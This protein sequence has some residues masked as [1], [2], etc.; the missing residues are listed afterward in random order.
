[1]KERIIGEI[2]EASYQPEHWHTVLKLLVE[3]THSKS[4][5]ILIKDSRF[6]SVS[7]FYQYGLPEEFSRQY[8]QVIHLDPCF[9]MENDIPLNRTSVLLDYHLT[10]AIDNVFHQTVMGPFGL[11]CH[12]CVNLLKNE[13]IHACIGIQRTAE[14]GSF[15]PETLELLDYYAGHMTRSLRIYREYVKQCS[16]TLAAQTGLD[17][18]CMGI[19]LF[20][21]FTRLLYMNR[22]AHNIIA[23]HPAIKL[24]DN[25]LIAHDR[26]ENKVLYDAITHAIKHNPDTHSGYHTMGLN[27]KQA[28]H[29]LAVSVV[30]V[31]EPGNTLNTFID[32]AHAILYLTDTHQPL[33]LSGEALKSVYGLTNSEAVVAI[34]LS[35]GFTLE[36]IAETQCVSINTIR[37]H[38]KSTFRK[39]NVARQSDVIRLV[40]SLPALLTSEAS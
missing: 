32:K 30:P 1:M 14:Q 31:F 24:S 38:L 21:E 10:A 28:S 23:N 20:D 26:E 34:E 39:L 2:Y 33:P 18:L 13:E 36:Q 19:V 9:S 3:V 5:A 29:P 35:N 40:M 16:N 15:E 25:R 11:Y 17:N 22:A 12:A 7:G 37:S 6:S 27:H 8:Q 4:A